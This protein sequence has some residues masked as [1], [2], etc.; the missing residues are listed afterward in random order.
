M[1]AAYL[2]TSTDSWFWNRNQQ[3]TERHISPNKT[4]SD[5]RAILGINISECS[6]DQIYSIAVIITLI[7]IL[8]WHF[9]R[10]CKKR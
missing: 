4:R 2:S 5:M 1:F 7:A 8:L 3:A 10:S 6:S 9:I